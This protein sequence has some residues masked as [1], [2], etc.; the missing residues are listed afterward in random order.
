MRMEEKR[1]KVVEE[2]ILPGRVNR[3]CDSV[4]RWQTLLLL[5]RLHL[6]N[7]C[8]RLA[9]LWKQR[10]QSYCLHF[11]FAHGLQKRMNRSES[12]RAQMAGGRLMILRWVRKLRGDSVD[13]SWV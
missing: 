2:G 12:E 5:L 10:G 7:V 3:W 4:H 9:C 8:S 1:V 6:E 13:F 11:R